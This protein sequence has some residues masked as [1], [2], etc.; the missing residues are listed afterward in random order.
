MNIYLW[1]QVP[2]PLSYS[3]VEGHPLA[4]S[5]CW[6]PSDEHTE[7]V[8]YKSDTADIPCVILLDCF[9]LLAKQHTYISFSLPFSVFVRLVNV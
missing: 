5:H 7:P 6:G 4:F 2:L 8:A 1:C 3:E 9:A